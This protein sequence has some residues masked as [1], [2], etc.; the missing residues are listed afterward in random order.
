MCVLLS[1][2]QELDP[3]RGTIGGPL[4]RV[5]LSSEAGQPNHTEVVWMAPVFVVV[6]LATDPS[7]PFFWTPTPNPHCGVRLG[8][9][10]EICV[11]LDCSFNAS[12]F[13]GG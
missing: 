13:D 7:P 9:S 2:T 1:L 11:S 8:L 4:P 3:P 12:Y 5:L 6:S 10:G